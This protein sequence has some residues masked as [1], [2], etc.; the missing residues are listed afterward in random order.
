MWS[1]LLP[2]LVY[3]ISDFCTNVTIWTGYQIFPPIRYS[4]DTEIWYN[5]SLFLQKRGKNLLSHGLWKQSE[6]VEL[7]KIA[8]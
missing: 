1:P 7:D 6:K 3:K 8:K 5:F 2:I 4:D